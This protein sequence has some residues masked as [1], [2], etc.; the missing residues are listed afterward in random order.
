M[1][2]YIMSV[3]GLYCASNVNGEKTG[4][5]RFRGLMSRNRTTPTAG[6]EGRNTH[7]CSEQCGTA[8]KKVS[9]TD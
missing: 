4:V 1:Q 3:R 9:A 6:V 2:S 5:A 8:C 7:W